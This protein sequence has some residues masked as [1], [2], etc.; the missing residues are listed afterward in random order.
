MLTSEML[1]TDSYASEREKNKA[2]LK[3][4]PLHPRLGDPGVGER[5]MDGLTKCVSHGSQV[6]W[7]CSKLESKPFISDESVS[8]PSDGG[9]YSIWVYSEELFLSISFC[10]SL[11]FGQC[12]ELSVP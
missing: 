11:Y 7:L 3:E 10:R 9:E 6:I 8:L 5:Q 2:E 1:M 12:D 4:V